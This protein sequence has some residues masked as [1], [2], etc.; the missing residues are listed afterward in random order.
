MTHVKDG[1]TCAIVAPKRQVSNR[2][3]F[4]GHAV[5]IESLFQMLLYEAVT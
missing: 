2:E 3:E 4:A 5:M 1:G